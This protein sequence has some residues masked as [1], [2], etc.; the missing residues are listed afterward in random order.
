MAMMTVA[1]QAVELDRQP[2]HLAG[3][4]AVAIGDQQPCRLRL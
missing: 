4:E 3:D 1:W 2:L